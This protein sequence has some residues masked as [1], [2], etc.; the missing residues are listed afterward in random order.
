MITGF[1]AGTTFT[2]IGDTAYALNDSVNA[3]GTGEIWKIANFSSIVPQSPAAPVAPAP[4]A[5]APPSPTKPVGI[6]P[7]NT[8]SGPSGSSS[9]MLWMIAIA[10][11]ALGAF[12]VAGGIATKPR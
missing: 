2:F 12:A 3:F 11:A 9:S 1:T 4:T 10:A 5:V 6:T 8:G 7:P